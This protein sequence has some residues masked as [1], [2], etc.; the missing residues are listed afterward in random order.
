[1]RAEDVAKDLSDPLNFK[2][3]VYRHY[4]GGMYVALQLVRHHETQALYVVYISMSYGHVH[5]RE[6]ATPGADSWIDKVMHP[7]SYSRAGEWI[8]R[9]TYVGP[10]Y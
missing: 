3:G 8:Q 6:W 5:L 4:K 9:F 10:A 1:M 7:A 2:P